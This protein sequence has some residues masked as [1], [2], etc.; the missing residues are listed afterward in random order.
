MNKE[1]LMAGEKNLEIIFFRPLK[2]E[3][4]FQLMGYEVQWNSKC[5]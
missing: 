4:R 5:T 3:N 1:N 2:A